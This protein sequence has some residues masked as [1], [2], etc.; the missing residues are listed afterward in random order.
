M[1]SLHLWLAL[2]ENMKDDEKYENNEIQGKF[3][4]F[5]IFAIPLLKLS[6]QAKLRGDKYETYS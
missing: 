4:R 5:V 1:K 2:I 6:A 3:V